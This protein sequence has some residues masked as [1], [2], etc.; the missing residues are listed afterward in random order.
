MNSVEIDSVIS[1]RPFQYDHFLLKNPRSILLPLLLA[2]IHHIIS[3]F[4]Q[5]VNIFCN[6]YYFSS[7]FIMF[8]ILLC[9]AF[10][11][12]IIQGTYYI[13]HSI[14]ILSLVIVF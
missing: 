8:L 6:G 12:F 9:V 7:A 3:A 10:I 13:L 5:N 11:S 4:I 2:K 14:R 1:Y